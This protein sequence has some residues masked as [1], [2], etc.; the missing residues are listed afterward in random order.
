MDSVT[1]CAWLPDSERFVSGSIDKHIYMWHLDGRCI[2]HWKGSRINDL[3][4][5]R[6]GKWMVSTSN[7]KKF[8]L[9]DLVKD[10]EIAVQEQESIISLCLSKHSDMLLV[11]LQNQKI[12]LWDLNDFFASNGAISLPTEPVRVASLRKFSFALRSYD[13]VT[14]AAL[15]STLRLRACR[16]KSVGGKNIQRTSRAGRE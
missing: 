7:E 8:H 3:A 6:S 13:P 2:R 4:I 5:S 12:H 10:T 14:V 9:Y 16:G 15:P 1:S 11:N